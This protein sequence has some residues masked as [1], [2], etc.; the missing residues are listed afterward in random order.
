MQSK[1]L[2]LQ[3]KIADAVFKTQ[4]WAHGSLVIFPI[5]REPNNLKYPVACQKCGTET[6][7]ELQFKTAT[8]EDCKKLNQNR[9]NEKQSIE[10]S[11]STR[12]PL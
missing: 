12:E 5:H 10:K 2:T 11:D 8:C 1:N 9:L 3:S 6:E 4:L 7:R